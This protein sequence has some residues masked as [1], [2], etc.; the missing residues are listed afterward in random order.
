MPGRRQWKN[1]G[2]GDNESRADRRL[3]APVVT[4]MQLSA[5][6]LIQKPM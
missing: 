1:G 2:G 3:V 4:T 6:L 5:E